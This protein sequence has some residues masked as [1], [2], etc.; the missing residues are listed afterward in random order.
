MKQTKTVMRPENP[1]EPSEAVQINQALLAE[2]RWQAVTCRDPEE[3]GQ[4]VY[5]V[6]TTGIY[7]R[8]S[9]PS[10]TAKRQNVVVFDTAD[11]TLY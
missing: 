6:K 10:R 5:A 11:L 8:P 1:A 9:C 2:T 4:F 3:D 7:C